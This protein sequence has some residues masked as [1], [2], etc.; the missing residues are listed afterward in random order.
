MRKGSEEY[1]PASDMVLLELPWLSD[2]DFSRIGNLP[3]CVRRSFPKG[4][5]IIVQG[6]S[7]D[8]IYMIRKG[9]VR[10]SIFNEDGDEKTI[11]IVTE[12]NIFGEISAF[13]GSVSP[14]EVV[15]ITDVDLAVVRSADMR[16]DL[17]LMHLLTMYLIRE[18]RLLVSQLED[19]VFNDA[20]TRLAACLYR[21]SCKY[22]VKRHNSVRL[23]VRFTHQEMALLL[24]TSRVT[25][26]NV[27]NKLRQD[28]LIDYEDG[29]VII[30]DASG[31][32]E[33]AGLDE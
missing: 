8:F 33:V 14:V 13:D 30:L 2:F 20:Q 9:R 17:A 3:C 23:P 32:R 25:V 27:I 12:R 24:G 22:G 28:R 7:N 16:K 11:A 19:L 4:S 10:L 15:A 18:N 31:L 6:A 1:K 26:S 29:F 5:P 21:L